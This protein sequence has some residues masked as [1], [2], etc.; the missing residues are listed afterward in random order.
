[1]ADGAPDVENQDGQDAAGAGAYSLAGYDYQIDVSIWLAL[2][3]LLANK[4][5]QSIELEPATEE[6]IEA[7]WSRA[8]HRP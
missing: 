4:V 2:D 3:L 1:M 6:D 5:A 8:C 7:E